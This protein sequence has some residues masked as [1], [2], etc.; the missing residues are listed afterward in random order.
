[1][2]VIIIALH[3]EKISNKS[4]NEL[5]SDLF[6][7]SVDNVTQRKTVVKPLYLKIPRSLICCE[8]EGSCYLNSWS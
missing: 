6:M 8:A 7:K 3:L 4:W 1:M 5:W 2:E